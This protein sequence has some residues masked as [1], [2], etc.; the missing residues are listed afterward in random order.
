LHGLGFVHEV[1]LQLRGQAGA[2]QV[3]TARIGVV[4]VG[5]LPYVGCLLLRAGDA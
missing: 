3:T 5:A 4:A 1:C 2:R